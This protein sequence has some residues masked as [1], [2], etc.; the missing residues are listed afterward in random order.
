MPVKK[1]RKKKL[2]FKKQAIAAIAIFAAGFA[3][4]ASG[5][6]QNKANNADRTTL[7]NNTTKV[8]CHV[9]SV[10][11]RSVVYHNDDNTVIKKAY[12]LVGTYDNDG[13]KAVITLNEAYD[14]KALASE[15]IN[16]DRNIFVNTD[17]LGVA[18]ITDTIIPDKD[19]SAV[20]G[21]T[22]GAVVMCLGVAV[23]LFPTAKLKRISSSKRRRIR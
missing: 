11:E 3:M 20:P 13:N 6:S 5:I 17:M 12:S 4:L 7:L 14:D 2:K 22:A 19:S 15:Q 18:G 16:T 10:T 21:I 9:T 1:K 8:D 23:L